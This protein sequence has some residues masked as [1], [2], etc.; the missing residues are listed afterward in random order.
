M[1]RFSQMEGRA[2]DRAPVG[3]PR[4]S[5]SRSGLMV[6]NKGVLSVMSA[7]LNAPMTDTIELR[8]APNWM[9]R[10]FGALLA[11]VRLVDSGS[12]DVLVYC[13]DDLPGSGPGDWRLAGSVDGA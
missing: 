8:R 7:E 3:Y 10:F 12:L 4:G 2:L 9:S 5:N 13:R 6:D 1:V 11:D